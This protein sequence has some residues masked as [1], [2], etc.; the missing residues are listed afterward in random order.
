MENVLFWAKNDTEAEQIAVNDFV[1]KACLVLKT[2][3][4]ILETWVEHTPH[5][6]FYSHYN[7]MFTGDDSHWIQKEVAWE[8]TISD[9]VDQIY[10]KVEFATT[11]EYI[12]KMMGGGEYPFVFLERMK[13]EA[14]NGHSRYQ[15][16]VGQ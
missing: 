14:K 7:S 8:K 4:G 1:A 10:S 13:G 3:K 6:C 11:K 5:T 15:Y 16:H 2:Y 12:K 9:T